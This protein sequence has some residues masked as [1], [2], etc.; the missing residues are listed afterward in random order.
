MRTRLRDEADGE[1][2]DVATDDAVL[3]MS[4]SVGL[5]ERDLATPHTSA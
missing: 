5:D 4:G 1:S 2:A 3:D